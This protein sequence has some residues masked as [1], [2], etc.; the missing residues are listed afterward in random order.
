MRQS[1]ITTIGL[2]SD[3]RAALRLLQL[4]KRSLGELVTHYYTRW[5]GGMRY[6][7]WRENNSA[8]NILACSICAPAAAGK[9][10]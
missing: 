3:M 1:R 9:F 10:L 4:S 8:H 2:Q 7:A 6:Q 5:K